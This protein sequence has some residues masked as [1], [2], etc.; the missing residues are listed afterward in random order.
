LLV[1]RLTLTRWFGHIL[2]L[3]IPDGVIHIHPFL[4]L[5][6]WLPDMEVVRPIQ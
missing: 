1:F 2:Y 5:I 4:N 6:L 3:G